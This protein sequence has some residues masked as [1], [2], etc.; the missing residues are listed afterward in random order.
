MNAPKKYFVYLIG[1][2]VESGYVGVTCHKRRRWN[3]HSRSNY[4]VGEYIR[5]NGLEFSDDTM[6]ILYEGTAQE[7]FHVEASLRPT[8]CMGLNV[9]PGG[10]GGPTL[11][12]LERNRKISQALKGQKVTWGDKVSQTKRELGL[13]VGDKNPKAKKWKFTAP[14]GEQH[15][16]VGNK[17][18]F[19]DNHSLLASCLVYHL[20]AVVP[21]IS[22]T[23]GR[24]GFR[25]KNKNSLHRRLNSVGWMLETI[26]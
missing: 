1:D 21:P 5:N 16:V 13:A 10:H 18:Q 2:T 20:G 17:Q 25:S 7:C 22:K 11:Y 23:S 14:S 4:P 3:G 8:F 24:G 6:K 12:T 19:C 15:I 9:A 26:N